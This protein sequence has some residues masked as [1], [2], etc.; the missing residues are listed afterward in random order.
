MLRYIIESELVEYI[1]CSIL[2]I[3]GTVISCIIVPIWLIILF[4]WDAPATVYHIRTSYNKVPKELED[5]KWQFSR[6][7]MWP[8][9]LCIF[10]TDDWK[11]HFRQ[12]NI[13]KKNSSQG[14]SPETAPKDI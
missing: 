4:L 1:M 12:Y 8:L 9:T 14:Q 10:L 7:C 2:V 5:Y 3:I 6:V 11:D 13:L